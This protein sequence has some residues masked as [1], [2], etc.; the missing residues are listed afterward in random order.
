MFINNIYLNMSVT[1]PENFC[2]DAWHRGERKIKVDQCHQDYTLMTNK[3]KFTKQGNEIYLNGNLLT[4]MPNINPEDLA[5]IYKYY[6][7]KKGYK[8]YE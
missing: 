3:D 6:L 4:N 2:I 8:I 5:R 1:F 7:K